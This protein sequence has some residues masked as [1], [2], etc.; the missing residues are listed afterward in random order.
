MYKK[1]V[2]RA[3]IK[4]LTRRYVYL[5]DSRYYSEYSLFRFDVKTKDC[6]AF[7]KS[8]AFSLPAK[9]VQIGKDIYSVECRD[10]KVVRYSNLDKDGFEISKEVIGKTKMSFKKFA[11]AA[12]MD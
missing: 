12:V 5:I 7:W 10:L 9:T 1:G 11:I 6:V 4:W 2:P 3:Q 8:K